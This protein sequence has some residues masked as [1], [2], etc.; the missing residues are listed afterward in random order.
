MNIDEI[1]SEV[2]K[3][4]GWFFRPQMEFLYPYAQRANNIF[5]IGTYRGR[6]TLFWILANPDARVMTVDNCIGDPMGN[7]APG[8]SI[9]P[10]IP[11]RGNVVAIHDDVHTLSERFNWPI[12]FLFIDGSHFYYDLCRDIDDWVPK[13]HGVV[14]VHDYMDVW[15]TV[16]KGCDDKLRGKYELITD[17]YGLFVVRT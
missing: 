2:D 5:E 16:K 17:Q 15:P 14:V 3:I 9:D 4:P 1:I 10:S 6:S 8:T 7:V 13:T 12:D 11:I